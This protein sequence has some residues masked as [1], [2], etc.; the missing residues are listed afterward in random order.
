MN[1][2]ELVRVASSEEEADDR[3]PFCGHQKIG[4]IRRSFFKCYVCRKEWGIRKDC[5]LEGLKV[6]FTK[7][8]LVVKLFILS[9]EVEMDESYFG[10]RRKVKRGRGA[11]GK[12]PVFGI[13]ERE[14]KVKVEIVKDVTAETLL[15]EMIKKVKRESIIYTD[16]FKAYDGLVIYGFKHERIDKSIKFSN[17]KVYINGIEGFWS[18]AKEKA[19]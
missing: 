16:K 11:K 1:L 15:R 13:L 5:I 14:G 12:I 2:V 4:R 9:G 6:P 10:S 8:I 19:S 18:Y 7:F 3:C 17:G